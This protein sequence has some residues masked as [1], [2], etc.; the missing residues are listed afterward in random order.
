[1]KRKKYLKRRKEY[2][3]GIKGNRS[4]I[5]TYFLYAIII[6]PS[7]IAYF[8]PNYLCIS[9]FFN[10]WTIFTSLFVVYFS[11][12]VDLSYFILLLV[13]SYYFIRTIETKYGPRRLLFTFIAC[14]VLG[15]L[16]YLFIA[17]FYVFLP[18]FSFFPIGLASGGLLGTC[19]FSSLVSSYKMWHFS[20]IC[21][22]T[23]SII[24]FLAFYNIISK[25]I[26]SIFFHTDGPFF[27]Y[28]YGWYIPWY[29]FDLFGLLG[30]VIL[31][32]RYF[33]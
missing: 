13:I 33:K 30:A 26:T 27:F 9:S 29:I 20:N 22:K 6:V 25:V 11:N 21:L 8:Y 7:I 14:S 24:G 16:I 3:I 28:Y 1:M 5:G 15:G 17:L 32:E 23:S 12:V 19:L 31:Y 18:L 2:N 10:F 4:I